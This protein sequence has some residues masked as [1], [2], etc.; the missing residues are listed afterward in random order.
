MNLNVPVIVMD[1]I[2]GSSWYVNDRIMANGC[3]E[4]LAALTQGVQPK[5]IAYA[6]RALGR[7]SWSGT[8]D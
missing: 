2:A 5:A 8:S 6:V 7:C 1:S 3:T 4:A